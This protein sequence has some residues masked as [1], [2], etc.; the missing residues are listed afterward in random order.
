[1]KVAAPIH[2]TDV[3]GIR[4]GLETPDAVAD[5]VGE[6]DAALRDAGLS[7]YTGS[8]LV[9]E[10]IDDGVEMAVGVTHDPSFGPIVMTGMGGTLVELIK[11][12]SIR[13]TPLTDADV[14][15]MLDGLRMKPLLTG[16]RGGPAGGRRA[17]SR[18]CSTGS[19]RWSR[20]CP[21]SPS[22]TSTR[23]SCARRAWSPSTCA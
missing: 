4:L 9:Q 6:L 18:I 14:D 10:M 2:K 8:Y 19:T 16:Y 22:S 15:D 12:V 5:A 7:D 20:T 3:G 17:R 23:C 1:M 21:R 11:D 13:I